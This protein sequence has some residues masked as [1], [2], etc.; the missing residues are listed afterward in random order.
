MIFNKSVL[1]G[2]SKHHLYTIVYTIIVISITTIIIVTTIIIIIII[3]T[4]TH[5]PPL[6][7]S[8]LFRHFDDDVY[9]G[10]YILPGGRATSRCI[11]S[12]EKV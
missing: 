2:T 11:R 8:A 7:Y 4:T 9:L 10:T 6:G 3:I 12:F 5:L 1:P